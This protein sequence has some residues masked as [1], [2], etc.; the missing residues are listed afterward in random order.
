MLVTG[1]VVSE[2]HKVAGE[3]LGV[4]QPMP[5]MVEVVITVTRLIKK[6]FRMATLDH[7]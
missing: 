5:L 1:K 3:V 4:M 6:R 7:R 2:L